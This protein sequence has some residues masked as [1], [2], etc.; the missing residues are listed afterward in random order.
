M[1]MHIDEGKIISLIKSYTAKIKL[2]IYWLVHL[3]GIV[4]IV[5][6]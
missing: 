2:L 3:Q 6:V 4:E 5:V 1:T